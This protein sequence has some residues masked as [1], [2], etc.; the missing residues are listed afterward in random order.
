MQHNDSSKLHTCKN[1]I[2]NSGYWGH[3]RSHPGHEN[4]SP[5]PPRTTFENRERYGRSSSGYG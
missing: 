4:D 3:I 1:A 5:P 2:T